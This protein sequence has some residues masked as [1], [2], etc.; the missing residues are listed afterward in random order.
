VRLGRHVC[1]GQPWAKSCSSKDRSTLHIPSRRISKRAHRNRTVVY[2]YATCVTYSRLSC[3]VWT[4]V[5]QYI[6]YSPSVR[7]A[8]CHIRAIPHDIV[9]VR[10]RVQIEKC[11]GPILGRASSR[12]PL[13]EN[14]TLL[15]QNSRT[16]LTLSPPISLWILLQDRVAVRRNGDHGGKVGI[17]G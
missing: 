14:G 6:H 10:C 11:E 1:R 3:Y 5:A 16:M 2:T 8:E 13:F 7:R 4:K 9:F 15:Q 17:D 12:S